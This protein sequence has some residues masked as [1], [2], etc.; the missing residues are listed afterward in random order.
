[1]SDIIKYEKD[2]GIND[3]RVVDIPRRNMKKSIFGS[4]ELNGKNLAKTAILFTHELILEDVDVVVTSYKHIDLLTSI[5]CRVSDI[6]YDLQGYVLNVLSDPL[7]AN[8]K[9]SYIESGTL[10]FGGAYVAIIAEYMD[11]DEDYFKDLIEE[12]EYEGGK[13][14]G[15]LCAYSISSS[16]GTVPVRVISYNGLDYTVLS[17]SKS[18]YFRRCGTFDVSWEK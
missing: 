16:T 4:N 12:V 2:F 9:Y 15:I 11:E 13:V 1:M 8:N 7:S 5:L 18:I 10:L 17:L 14:A 6:G 3:W